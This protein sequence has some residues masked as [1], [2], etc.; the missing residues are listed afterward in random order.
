MSDKEK[1]Y[2]YVYML[3]CSDNTL[4][5]GYTTNP[6]KREETHNLGKGAKYTRVRLPVKVVY[7]E[8]YEEKSKALKREYALKQLTKLQK[9]ELILRQKSVII[10]L[11]IWT[12]GGY[13]DGENKWN[14]MVR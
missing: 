8:K 7:L 13:N 4:Y 10:N 1:K 11:E 6:K 3:R 2:H 9:E 5:S 14:F 12:C